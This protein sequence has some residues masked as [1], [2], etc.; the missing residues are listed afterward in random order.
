MQ[1]RKAFSMLELIFVIVVIGIL[2]KFGVE[3]LAQAYRNFIFSSINNRLQAQSEA[4]VELIAKRLEYRLK[5][6]VV[7]RQ[8]TVGAPTSI[9]N[10]AVTGSNWNVLEWAGEDI[11]GLRGIQAP[12]W[13]GVLDLNDPATTNA[14]L[15]SPGTNLS[16]VSTTIT[17]LGGNG[18]GDAAITMIG[19]EQ[20]PNGWGWTGLI[21]NNL[22]RSIHPI[23]NNA[24][25]LTGVFTN[26]EV[27]E[28][29]KLSWTAYGIW[30]DDSSGDLWLYYNYQ[31]WLGDDLANNGTAQL[32]M[33]NV[34]SF[35]FIAMDNLLKIQVC[36]DSAGI[37][38]G[39]SNDDTATASGEYAIC[40]D[41]TIF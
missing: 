29:Y 40:K 6:S 18:I 11:D 30:H 3:F 34:S 8:G 31:P 21:A 10:A 39:D 32:I 28:F 20:D 35:Q 36:V 37:I 25:N 17:N 5:G 7:A 16:N 24:N 33:E 14:N 4:A 26:T 27:F 9:R 12:F 1:K 38:S 15:V 22:G 41:K 13:S 19:G 2:S 23:G